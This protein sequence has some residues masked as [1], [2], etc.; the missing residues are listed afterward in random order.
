[1]PLVGIDE[2]HVDTYDEPG[3][4]VLPDGQDI[5]RGTATTART[6]EQKQR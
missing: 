4:S 1:M 6:H 5:T 2:R 3:F